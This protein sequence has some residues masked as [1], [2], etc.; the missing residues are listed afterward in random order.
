MGTTERLARFIVETSFDQIPIEAI[1]V[2]KEAMLDC[3]GVT[4]VGA[5]GPEGRIIAEFVQEMGGNPVA[6]VIGA[7]FRT[8]APWAALA[9]GTMG[10]AEDYDDSGFAMIGHPTVP[11][12][13]TILALGE[14]CKAPGKDIIEAYVIGFETESKLGR[15]MAPSGHYQRG[16]HATAT[17]G[18]M[19]A[20]AASAK[21]LKLDVQQTRM[22]LGVAASQA[23]G[24]RRNFGTMTKPFHAGNAARS[25]VVAG[26]LAKKGFTAHADIL[27]DHFGFFQVL[28]SDTPYDLDRVTDGLGETF[29]L[30]TSGIAVKLYPSCHD[31]HACINHVLELA[32]KHNISP[33]DARS[34]D[35]AVSELIASVATYTDP[36]T[37]LEGKF[38]LEYCIAR[39]LHDRAVRLEH[40][41]DEKV[42]EPKI[43]E[44]MKRITRHVD[45]SLRAL[46][47]ANVTI[48]LADGRQFHQGSTDVIKGFP[49]QPLTHEELTAKY[50][51]CARLLLSPQDVE[52]SLELME[53]LENLDGIADLMDLA[54]SRTSS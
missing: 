32:S 41:T 10:H 26:L 14:Q 37:A 16:W 40:F 35:Y 12:L 18:T 49:Q 51:D 42:N 44:T 23:S 46:A 9:N 38:S 2:A 25:G 20:A 19:G 45:P 28:K 53:K 21:L 29:E 30:T 48:K 1:K 33:Q 22:A 13:P 15:G 5:V 31:T 34:I 8:S 7:G 4:I 3:L 17:M 43:K 6:A 52:R 24:L 50:R 36:K 54:M 11:L 39:A 27:E 47:G